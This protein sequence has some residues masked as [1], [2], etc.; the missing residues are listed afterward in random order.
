M[1]ENSDSR[2]EQPTTRP[3]PEAMERAIADFLRA[4]GLPEAAEGEAPAKTA[5]AW[6]G[7]LLSGY[8]RDPMEVLENTWPD[9]TGEMVSLCGVPFVSVCAHHLLPFYGRVYL[10]YL[11]SGRLTGLS[12]LASLVDTLSRRLQVQ[13]R[14]TEEIADALMQGLS[15]RGA[16]VL[17]E[18]AHDCVGARSL[19]HRGAT[20]QTMAYRG[21]FCDDAG[22]RD[23]FLRL[24]SMEARREPMNGRTPTGDPRETERSD[25]D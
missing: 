9:Q 25:N 12:R 3:D 16:A 5:R 8:R 7:E 6:A 2:P 21:A 24:A 4:A 19:Q 1:S 11:P 17:I 18:A 15:P 20:V 23:S 14:L 10:A 13:E 22:F